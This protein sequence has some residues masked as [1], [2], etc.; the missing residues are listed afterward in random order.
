MEYSLHEAEL[1]MQLGQR[2]KMIRLKKNVSQSQLA[3]A[4]GMQKS[5]ISRI[6]AGNINITVNSLL[7]I[8]M[9]LEVDVRGIFLTINPVNIKVP[10]FYVR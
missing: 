9:A 7:R 4:T 5:N 3:T 10:D 2:M 1:L 6:E 8:A